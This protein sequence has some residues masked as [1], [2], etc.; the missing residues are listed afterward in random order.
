MKKLLFS[1]STLLLFTAI[2]IGQEDP[3]KA[4]SKAGRALGS[5]NLDPANNEGKLM[6][7]KDLI[8]IAAADD[9]TAAKVKTWQTRGE[10]YAALADQDIG[11]ISLDQEGTYVP[12]YPDAPVIAAE[13][14]SK[15]LEMAQKKYEK[16]DAAKG[17]KESATKL[18]ALGNSQIRRAD[19]A[20]AFNSL[21]KV[22]EVNDILTGNGD[23]PVIPV[24]EMDNHNFVLAFCAQ[25]AGET[26][27]AKDI[28]KGLYEGD[29]EE[30]SVYASY[31]NLLV[32]EGN[33]DEAMKVLDKGNKLFPTSSEILFA[34]INILIQKQDYKALEAKLKAAIEAEPNNPSV[35]SAL[36]NV[37]MNLFT[38]EFS[39]DRTS[40]TAQ[41]YFDQSL[42]YFNKASELDPKMFDAVYSIGSLHFNRAV[43]LIKYAGTLTIKEQEEYDAVMKEATERMETALPFFQKSESL[44][45]NDSNTL[46]ALSEIYARMGDFDKSKEFKSRLQTVQDGG[47][48]AS[49][50]FKQ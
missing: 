12:K 42:E 2:A 36:G 10:I 20:G 30:P 16:K 14:F 9:E 40:E 39:K 18:N 26:D 35:Y 34:S 50:Y 43:E 19:Y 6:E 41:G 46:I 48:N 32:A 31:A 38:D 25:A 21:S 24:E 11:M 29:S 44:N 45:A 28:F 23:D 5:F 3:G 7:A 17:L 8:E 4:L 47:E 15:A 33:V 49:S 37:Y 22:S 13:S 1:L 27:K